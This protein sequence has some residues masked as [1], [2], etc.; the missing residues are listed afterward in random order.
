M[1]IRDRCSEGLDA[2]SSEEGV[3]SSAGPAESRGCARPVFPD[4]R[5]LLNSPRFLGEGCFALFRE[6]LGSV[7]SVSV[8]L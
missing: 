4:V 3:P 7:D 6:V 8:V 5:Q 1:C 2:L